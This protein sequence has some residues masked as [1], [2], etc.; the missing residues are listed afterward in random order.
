MKKSQS[1]R[2]P[3][4]V[5]I[6][7]TILISCSEKKTTDPANAWKNWVGGPPPADV[8]L[9]HANYWQSAHWTKEY[10]LYLELKAPASWRNQFIELNKMVR[11]D[12]D[13]ALPSD[14]PSWFAPD[15]TMRIFRRI[16]DV[17]GSIYYEDTVTGKM[18]I[19]EI[20]L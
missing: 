11:S 1:L 8:Q 10:I 16:D 18:L 3:L 5:I 6:C 2:L 9:L 12:S 7:V 15:K 20:Q 4:T 14:A 17:E 13:S 19:Y